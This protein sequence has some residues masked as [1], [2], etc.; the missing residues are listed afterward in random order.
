MDMALKH[1]S[2]VNR[3]QGLGKTTSKLREFLLMP[4]DVNGKAIS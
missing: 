2:L 4:L 1:G 3:L